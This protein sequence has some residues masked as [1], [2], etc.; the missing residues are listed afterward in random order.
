MEF[1]DQDTKFIHSALAALSIAENGTTDIVGVRFV[2]DTN[3]SGKVANIPK[4]HV[5]ISL[6]S[7][8]SLTSF[9]IKDMLNLNGVGKYEDIRGSSE[10]NFPDVPNQATRVYSFDL[11]DLPE[12]WREDLSS[13]VQGTLPHSGVEEL[14][15]AK[16]SIMEAIAEFIFVTKRDER[17]NVNYDAGQNN[18]TL[19]IPEARGETSLKI[20]GIEEDNVARELT[21]DTMTITIPADVVPNIDAL[22]D[23]QK[24]AAT[25]A[26]ENVASTIETN[27]TLGRDLQNANKTIADLQAANAAEVPPS[28]LDGTQQ[29]AAPISNEPEIQQSI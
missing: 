26:N 22:R 3:S 2:N 25:I 19:T 14:N 21:G 7:Q 27:R 17:A 6:N 9:E 10:D 11:R 16:A 4:P 13:K 29:S 24:H 8:G 12:S 5:E 15:N 18:Y 1:T 20:F 23:A 28:E